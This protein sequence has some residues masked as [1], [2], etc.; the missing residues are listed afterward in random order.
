MTQGSTPQSSPTGAKRQVAVYVVPG[1]ADVQPQTFHMCPLG[2]QLYSPQALADFTVLEVEV[3]VPRKKGPPEKVVCT[4]AVV[5]CQYE[6][7]KDRYRVWIK[8]LDL[9]PAV[10]ERIRCTSKDGQHLC[11]YC[12]N[13]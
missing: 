8:F 11:S 3:D 1:L 6:K 13:F 5:R 7:S 4:G 10:S 9:D 12:E 2:M